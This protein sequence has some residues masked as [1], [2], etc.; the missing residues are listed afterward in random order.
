MPRKFRHRTA[1]AT[2]P[3]AQN[4]LRKS[5]VDS[6]TACMRA[7]G[8]SFL[9]DRQISH[10]A[11]APACEWNPEAATNASSGRTRMWLFKCLL[12]LSGAGL[13]GAAFAI[14]VYDAYRTRESWRQY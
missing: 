7:H 2:S 1:P 5:R 12:L 3:S 6:A 13:V 4:R 14:V 8:A 9:C 11:W 10:G